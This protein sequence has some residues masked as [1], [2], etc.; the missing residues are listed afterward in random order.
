MTERFQDAIHDFLR[1]SDEFK[2]ALEV[3]ALPDEQPEDAE[4]PQPSVWDTPE[5]TRYLAVVT[6]L[7]S[8][9]GE[10]Q[11]C[12]FIFRLKSK[13][14]PSTPDVYLLEHVFPIVGRFSITM[15]QPR[16]NTLNLSGPTD[17]S[18]NQ[19]RTEFTLT[20]TPGHE[21]NNDTPLELLTRDTVKLREVLAECKRLRAL[22]GEF[23]V[24]TLQLVRMTHLLNA[25]SADS[26]L[27]P[28]RP[29]AAH[30]PDVLPP[31]TWIIPYTYSGEPP[32]LSP[33]P[34]DLRNQHKSVD[35]LL[36]YA[37]AGQPGDD[38][39]DISL[40][41][42]EWIKQKLHEQHS[43]AKYHMPLKLRLGTF[44]VNGKMPSQDLSPWVRGRAA[45]NP[46]VLPPLKNVSPLSI[47]VGDSSK[48]SG[49]YLGGASSVGTDT[50]SLA[51]DTTAYSASVPSSIA[52]SSNSATSAATSTASDQTA[53]TAIDPAQGP[54]PPANADQDSNEKEN[55]VAEAAK[56]ALYLS[57]DDP[58][59]LV[60]AFQEVDLSTE[61]LLY[62][63]KT[64]REE[65]WCAAAL[66]GLGEKA[67][68]Y[69]KL[70]SKQLVGMLLVLFVKKSL[71][72]CFGDVK[73]TS[74]GAGILGLMGNKGGTAVRILFTPPVT[75]LENAGIHVP[76]PVSMTFVNAHLAAFDEG[77]DRRNSDF[78]LLCKRLQF[79]SGIPVQDGSPVEEDGY[80]QATV[81]LSIYQSDVLFWLKWTTD[82]VL[83]CLFN[84]QGD[85]NYRINL[86]DADV[87]SLLGEASPEHGLSQLLKFDQL[88]LAIRTQNAFVNF[89]EPTI[90]HLPR[91]PAW[92]DRILRMRS[93][94][95]QIENVAYTSHSELTMSDHKPV[96]ADFHVNV[97]ILDTEKLDTFIRGLWREA[98]NFEHSDELPKLQVSPLTVDF[99]SIY[100]KRTTTRTLELKNV[101]KIPCTYRFVPVSTEAPTHP[102]WLRVDP[103]SV[104]RC[105]SSYLPTA[106][107]HHAELSGSAFA[108]GN[109]LRDTDNQ[110]G[111]RR[112]QDHFV[113]ITAQYQRTCFATSLDR[114]VHLSGPVRSS[115]KLELLPDEKI[116]NAPREVMRLVNWLMSNGSPNLVAEIRECLDTG[117]EFPSHSEEDGGA[118][119]MAFATCLFEFMDSLPESVIPPDLHVRCAHCTSREQA[120]ELL[121]ELPS[122]SV[123][124]WIS[125]TAFLHFISQQALS[126]VSNSPT[127]DSGQL[128]AF[129]HFASRKGADRGFGVI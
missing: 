6:H 106:C 81:P 54:P 100:H 82:S 73:A 57:Q 11:G 71:R 87:R 62:S 66:A 28:S 16:R 125:V 105:L 49:D 46:T 95:V 29:S 34:S 59:M 52:S 53:R 20:I 9:T 67:V 102:E 91:K 93:P 12:V 124:V 110:P 48:S 113:S 117:A 118:M 51:S 58:D 33:V 126:S 24:G 32:I 45:Q 60:L 4:D 7:D 50:V 109:G 108:R 10:E 21:F 80:A 99:G 64:T 27:G 123:N 97:P 94:T 96:S 127:S 85:L 115:E 92:T 47:G 23:A 78:Q 129:A 88:G 26:F 104:R 18:L 35:E 19:P 25:L 65:A 83:V 22:S 72:S 86:A 121:D 44:N 89:L 2:L 40:I 36:S 128:G 90:L 13:R 3:R 120:F 14:I 107:S 101:G 61:A 38:V 98:T 77:Y 75:E 74:V 63:T 15:A 69:E 55:K 111:R 31:Y 17:L 39:Y 76:Q 114:L 68:E 122:A 1:S 79:D 112:C 119:A 103:H 70:A 41:R 84:L 42:E 37:T 56:T 43:S 30:N 116:L 5:K 8:T